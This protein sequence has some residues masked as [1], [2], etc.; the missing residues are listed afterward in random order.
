MISTNG[1]MINNHSE[2]TIILET[3][4]K[5]LFAASLILSKATKIIIISIENPPITLKVVDTKVNINPAVKNPIAN[6]AKIA[7][8]TFLIVVS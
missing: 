7:K 2:I 3:K 1:K 6:I 5:I 4:P 8:N